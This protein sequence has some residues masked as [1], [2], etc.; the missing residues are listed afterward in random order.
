MFIKEENKSK[1]TYPRRKRHSLMDWFLMKE[2]DVFH[3]FASLPNSQVIGTGDASF[4]FVPGTREDRILLVAHADTVWGDDEEL[5]IGYF[6][7]T[8]FSCK[9]KVGIGADDRAGC[10]MAWKLRNLGHSI[11]IPNAEES[12]CVGSRFLSKD[13][14]WM[15][16]V[17]N[18]RF[19]IEMDRMNDKD[20][21]FY[22]V[23]SEKFTEW[24]ESKFKGY[25]K[26]SGSFTDIGV[27]CETI[28]GLNISIGYYGQHGDNEILKEN[29]W[30]RTLS[31]MK[32]VLQEKEIP[33]FIQDPKPPVVEW[34]NSHSSRWPHNYNNGD[35]DYDNR[36]SLDQSGYKTNDSYWKNGSKIVDSSKNKYDFALDSI[37]VCPHCDFTQ[38]VSEWKLSGENCVGCGESF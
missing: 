16:I 21:V 10:A 33:Q 35:Y 31:M 38:D 7:G 29:E 26:A 1:I 37:I 9:D 5:Q 25:K 3:Q 28:C 23:G 8:Y 18:H 12:G 19:A 6:S 17:N 15:D 2:Q 11:L 4:V 27:L 13:R 14:V 24:C 34:T 36:P 22:R 32:N 30:Q 20:L